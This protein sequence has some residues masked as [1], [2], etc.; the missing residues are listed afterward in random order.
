MVLRQV[1]DRAA[2]IAGTG[3]LHPPVSVRAMQVLNR[4]IR[5]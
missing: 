1:I 3:I 4:I 5:G 2:G